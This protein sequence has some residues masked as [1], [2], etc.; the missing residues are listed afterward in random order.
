MIY[1]NYL[2]RG[3]NYHKGVKNV[4][5]NYAFTMEDQDGNDL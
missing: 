5:P 2:L 4:K 1:Y 3:S